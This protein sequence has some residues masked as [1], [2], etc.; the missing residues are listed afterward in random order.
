VNPGTSVPF[1]PSLSILMYLDYFGFKEP[2]FSIAPDPRY[3]YMS[4]R[5]REALAHLLFGLRSEGG[6][7]LLSGEVGTGKTTVCRCLLEQAPDEVEIAFVLNPKLTT[8]ELLATLCDELKI[9]YPEGNTS[10]KLFIDRI[11]TRL[12]ENHAQG[13]QTVLIIDEAQN[14]DPDVLEQIRL[15]TNLE[16]NKRKLLLVIMLGQPELR[17]MLGRPGLRQ[18]AQR[19]TA[20]Y[21][22]EPLTF[23]ETTAYLRHRLAVAGVCRPIFTP[24]AI[25]RIFRIT[26][27]IPRRINVLCDRSLL[28]AYVR[29][30]DRV[31]A[32]IVSKAAAEAFERPPYNTLRWASA[33]LLLLIIAGSALSLSSFHLTP[34][35]ISSALPPAAASH[36][37]PLLPPEPSLSLTWPENIP[38][39]QSRQLA[40]EALF[41]QWGLPFEPEAEICTQVQE[42]GHAC[43]S[44]MD[45]LDVLRRFNLPAVLKMKTEEGEGFFAALIGLNGENATFRLA[46]ETVTV[47][48]KT[49]QARW[50]GEYT[51][52]WRQPPFSG[53]LSPGTTGPHIEWLAERLAI[54]QGID[55]PEGEK[56]VLSGELLTRLKQFQFSRG[57]A[58]D[59][60]AGPFTLV[61]LDAALGGVPL[62]SESSEAR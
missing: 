47:P 25:R 12:L 56:A 16:T 24:A 8:V 61:L 40:F 48:L 62:L 53:I 27:G 38:L 49:L 59:G 15:L 21:H 23:S 51:L 22:L 43:L 14:L 36:E 10:H 18:L 2:P 5:H 58:P 7:V 42:K 29:E 26:K 34:V 20:R 6:F 45:G 32:R 37:I 44:R 4:E 1:T 57:I 11:N 39:E 17:E 31:D 33:A 9:A 28:G 52:L 30:K 46:S 19:I 50:G 41:E 60:V 35:T 55:R 13:R 54:V 3:L